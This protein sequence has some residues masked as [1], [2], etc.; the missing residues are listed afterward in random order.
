MGLRVATYNIHQCVGGDGIENPRRIAEVLGEI[1]ADIVALQEV[2][3]HPEISH[4]MLAYLAAATKM[5]PLEGF[6]LS[7]A[8][9]RY[10]NAL[11]SRVPISAVNRVDISVQ[12]REPRGVVEVVVNHNCQTVAL[13]ATHLGLSIGERRKQIN[14]LLKMIDAANVDMS[15]LL[16]DLNEWFPWGR[17]LRELHRWFKAADSPATFPTRRPFLKLD[18]ILVRPADRVAT[19]RTHSTKLSR[20]AS[21]HLPLVADIAF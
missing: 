11:L 9:S 21:D 18:R 16:G 13:W 1:N 3:S 6:T 12:G 14:T 4:D 2:T 7:V 15:I 20:V 17:P 8:G 5:K 19:I 10:G